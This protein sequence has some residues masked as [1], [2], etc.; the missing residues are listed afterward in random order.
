MPSDD[1]H[2][3]GYWNGVE[4][5][6]IP[7][8]TLSI[9]SRLT[10]HRGAPTEVDPITFSVI[11]Y[12]LMNANFEHSR[13]IQRLSVSPIVMLAQDFQCSV[14]LEDGDLV[15]VGPNIQYFSNAQSL[16]AKWILENRSDSP[17]IAP[18]DM[19][20]CN[21]PFIGAPHQPDTSLLNP[22]FVQGELF[23]WIGNTLHYAD[24]GGV[25]PGS[26]CFTATDAWQ[27]PPAF[28]ALKLVEHGQ[29]RRDMEELFLRQSR[30]RTH[31]RMDLR[32]AVAANQTT[33]RRIVELV[34]RYGADRVKAV[35]RRTVDASETLFVERL[36]HVPDGAWSA[37]T[38]VEAAVPGD[39]G[40]YRYQ[41]NIEKR[42][43]R[44]YV[45]NRG[46]DRQAGCINITY[47]AFAGGVL[48]ALVQAVAPDLAGAYGGAHR[49]VVFQPQ[50][51]LLNC[52]EFPAAVS[53]S[54]AI[55][56]ELNI[57]LATHAVARMLAC[58]DRDTIGRILGV[59]QPA[60]YGAIYMGLDADGR[61]FVHPAVDNM[62]GSSGGL[63]ERDGVE[64]GGHYWI[65]G[66]IAEN[67]E[68]T[69]ANC[70]V[71][72]LYR[73][74][75]PGDHAG[76]GRTR[77]GLGLVQAMVPWGARSFAFAVATNE[78][79][80]R[81]NGMLGGN[82]GGRGWTL[83]RGGVQVRRAFADGH[84]PQT[85]GALGGEETLV[86]PKAFGLPVDVDGGVFEWAGAAT[87]GCGDPLLRDPEA[88]QRDVEAGLFAPDAASA[89][90]GVV[91][92]QDRAGRYRI[93]AAATEE[94]RQTMLSA[95]LGRPVVTPVRASSSAT[96]LVRSGDHWA[97]GHCAHDLGP[98]RRSYKPATEIR[99]DLID[100]F[101]PGF[102]SPHPQLAAE[103][104]LRSFLCP[105][106]GAR[107][108]TELA[109][110]GDPLLEDIRLAS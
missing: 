9:D 76:A 96:S 98:T 14:L 6:Y 62:I 64:A 59:T 85:I 101:A 70:P 55:T 78:G 50:A 21:D 69:E 58:G 63:P 93:D 105:S 10:L 45:D 42:G 106:C 3:P 4:R 53:A 60:F 33:A 16:I 75:L 49:R 12:A 99:T 20:L 47:V 68:H 28:P 48:S 11:R 67:V 54:G 56:S 88:C 81:A 19:F 61:P 24:V 86:P 95:R 29:I 80:T 73:R 5:S 34:E 87:A 94:L 2:P 97:C 46:T 8:E 110:V 102:E 91:L 109:R 92:Q 23:C 13:L 22:I 44:I 104:E 36:R 43:T 27:D 40:L 17:G 83:L 108:D 39:W 90:H 31:V 25:V 7:G 15:F 41:V 72:Y 66:G 26:F 77:G 38:F 52:A 18:G 100:R 37:R 107:L 51:G 35:M 84:V 74:F 103:L 71:L 30:L 65:P 79:F 1:Q 32:A 89:V 57:N 82:P